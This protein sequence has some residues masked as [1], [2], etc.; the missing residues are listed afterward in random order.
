V[1]YG[2]TDMRVGEV[3]EIV[4]TERHGRKADMKDE[5]SIRGVKSSITSFNIIYSTNSFT[6]LLRGVL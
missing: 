4:P 6:C 5:H 2:G 1:L 3:R